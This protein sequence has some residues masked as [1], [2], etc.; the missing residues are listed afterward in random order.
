MELEKNIGFGN[1]KSTNNSHKMVVAM[2]GRV[3]HLGT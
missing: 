3:H 2:F 1:L